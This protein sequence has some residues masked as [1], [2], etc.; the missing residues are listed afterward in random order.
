LP[1]LLDFV[2]NCEDSNIWLLSPANKEVISNLDSTNFALTFRE[3]QWLLDLTH[4][5][6]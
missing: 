3:D 5:A 1:N 2:R 4:Q 6:Q